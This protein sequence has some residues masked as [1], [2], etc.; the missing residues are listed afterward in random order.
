ME[1]DQK[2]GAP[3]ASPSSDQLRYLR[4]AYPHIHEHKQQECCTASFSPS[5]YGFTLAEDSQFSLKSVEADKER[6][7]VV[8]SA[9]KAFFSVIRSRASVPN[10]KRS[11]GSAALTSL[12]SA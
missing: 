5:V 8:S 9:T 6:H 11:G 10:G 3:T 4:E 1:S 12:R 7:L 2:D